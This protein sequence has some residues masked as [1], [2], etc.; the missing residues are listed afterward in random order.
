MENPVSIFPRFS[1]PLRMGKLPVLGKAFGFW[2]VLKA[3]KTFKNLDLR[4]DELGHVRKMI[5]HT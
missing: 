4:L 1:H 5:R 3:S 2:P